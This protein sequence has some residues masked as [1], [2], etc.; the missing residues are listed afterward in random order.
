MYVALINIRIINTNSK[1]VTIY[2]KWFG[3]K[4]RCRNR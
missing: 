3:Q 4:T 1:T 2:V